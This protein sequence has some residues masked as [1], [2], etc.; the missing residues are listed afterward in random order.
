LGEKLW[1]ASIIIGLSVIW[2]PLLS[3]LIQSAPVRR[4]LAKA[5]KIVDKLLG[6]VLIGLGIKVALS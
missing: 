6:G 5:Q 2:W 4:G 3:L 1:Y